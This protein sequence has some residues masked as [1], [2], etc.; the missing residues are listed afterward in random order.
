MIWGETLQ[1]TALVTENN[2]LMIDKYE[3]IREEIL[4]AT[5]FEKNEVIFN[6]Y[7]NLLKY[8]YISHRAYKN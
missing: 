6:C 4:V 3:K 7:N 8:L 1:N 5:D 2:E